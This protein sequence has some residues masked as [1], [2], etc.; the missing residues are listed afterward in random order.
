MG[1]PGSLLCKVFPSHWPLSQPSQLLISLCPD[2][3][4]V[5]GFLAGAKVRGRDTLNVMEPGWGCVGLG[6][7][8][9]AGH[10]FFEGLP[11]EKKNHNLLVR[12]LEQWALRK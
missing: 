5:S 12:K 1:P 6:T 11:Y 2:L 10:G 7:L 3:P 9:M 8:A 4:S